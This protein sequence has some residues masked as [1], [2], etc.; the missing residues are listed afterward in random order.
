MKIK[1]YE[2]ALKRVFVIEETRDYSLVKV[3]K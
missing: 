3:E 1:T 2:E